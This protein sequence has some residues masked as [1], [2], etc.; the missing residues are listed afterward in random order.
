MIRD[1]FMV[2]DQMRAAF[3]VVMSRNPD[4]V[5]KEAGGRGM[6][7]RMGSGTHILKWPISAEL[8]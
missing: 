2:R 5:V 4:L 8:L 7:L 3:L 6:G 1:N